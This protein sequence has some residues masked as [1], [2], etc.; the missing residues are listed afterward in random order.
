MN[1][2]IIAKEIMIKDVITIDPWQS[3]AAVAQ[4][5]NHHAIG[6][7]PVVENEELVGIITSRDIRSSHP[8]RLV[9][10]VMTKKLIAVTPN[11]SLWEIKQLLEI[12]KIE[13]LPVVEAR[14]VLVGLINKV[15][16]F[17]YLGMLMD[18]L[19]NI[20]KTSYVYQ[21]IDNLCKTTPDIS[22]VFIDI[23]KFGEID[24]EFGHAIGD[25]ILQEIAKILQKIKPDEGYL[26]RYGGD[27]FAFVLP[28]TQKKAYDFA[29][30]VIK[31]I[32]DA[33]FSYNIDISVSIGI[34]GGQRHNLF[35]EANCASMLKNLFNMASLAST[36]AKKEPRRIV[37][38]KGLNVANICKDNYLL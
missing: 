5:M 20:P 27:E 26:C 7:L 37:V 22:I 38:A 36:K 31:N 23:D 11:T 16:V 18:S 17:S 34:A 9:A 25:L 6:C 3:L 29:L 35:R 1:D 28:W 21:I 33:D 12:H 2:A 30:T 24:K 13:K 19:T 8:N 4:L 15:I 10:D 32:D 14:N